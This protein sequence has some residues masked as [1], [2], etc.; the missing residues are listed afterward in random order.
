M[1]TPSR[2]GNRPLCVIPIGQPNTQDIDA[3][4]KSPDRRLTLSSTAQSFFSTN[5]YCVTYRNYRNSPFPRIDLSTRGQR[6]IVR[7]RR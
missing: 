1:T 5:V 4:C 3:R 7:W 2:H 6:T